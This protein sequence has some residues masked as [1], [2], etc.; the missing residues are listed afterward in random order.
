MIS[1]FLLISYICDYKKS[2]VLN[3]K[4][5]IRSKKSAKDH[6]MLIYYSNFRKDF[7]F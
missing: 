4:S 5:F 3:I 7:L 1:F 6:R 2:K